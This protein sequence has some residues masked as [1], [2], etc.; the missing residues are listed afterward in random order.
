MNYSLNQFLAFKKKL[1]P[2]TEVQILSGSMEPWIKTGETVLVSPC[3]P[4]ELSPYDIIVFYDQKKTKLICHVFIKIVQD[5]LITKALENK[6]LDEPNLKHFLLGKVTKPK[7]N[8][9]QKFILRFL[10]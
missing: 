2:N 9:F 6:K 7:F 10:F 8:W 1:R 4:E 3:R 5:K